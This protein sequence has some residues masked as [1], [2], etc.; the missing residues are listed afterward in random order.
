MLPPE[1]SM[2][3]RAGRRARFQVN[4]SPL[5]SCILLLEGLCS[6]IADDITLRKCR[7]ILAPYLTSRL[8]QSEYGFSPKP[9]AGD[10]YRV[11]DPVT[12]GTIR[13]APVAARSPSF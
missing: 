2:S 5:S 10:V 11:I 3:G 8:V 1:L 7:R 6:S 9:S 13:V 4:V 12:A